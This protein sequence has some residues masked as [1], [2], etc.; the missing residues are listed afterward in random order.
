[1]STSC[2][3]A[4]RDHRF[5][6][7]FF[8][9]FVIVF[10]LELLGKYL[11]LFHYTSLGFDKMLHFLAGIMCGIFGVGLLVVGFWNSECE[12]KTANFRIWTMAIATALII[13][14]SWEIAQAY[15]PW[16]R[17]FSDYNIPDTI[18]D[19]IWDTIGGIASGLFY[20]IKE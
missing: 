16:L 12:R 15:A 6:K 13:G 20:R 10:L 11:G 17:D 3:F 2:H 8:I 7:P 1:M 14:I 19:V 5:L 9:F 18:G 4:F